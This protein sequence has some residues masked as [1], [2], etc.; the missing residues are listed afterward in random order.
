LD[1]F[2]DF[3]LKMQN[4]VVNAISGLSANQS[5]N[6]PIPTVAVWHGGFGSS[7]SSDWRLSYTVGRLLG[8]HRAVSLSVAPFAFSSRR[9]AAVVAT[10][11]GFMNTVTD[12]VSLVA[13]IAV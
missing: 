11:G 4:L 8:V 13:I 10:A 12:S 7:S 3:R 9:R 2:R 5:V 1:F 6:Q